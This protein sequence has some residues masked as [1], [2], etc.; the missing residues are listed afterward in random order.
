[1]KFSLYEYTFPYYALDSRPKEK[2]FS[3][4]SDIFD[5]KVHWWLTG[6]MY[7]LDLKKHPPY[8]KNLHMSA[9]IDLKDEKLVNAFMNGVRTTTQLNLTSSAWRFKKSGETG[10][11]LE[12]TTRYKSI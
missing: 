2:L 10:V 8:S 1:M 12:W 9:Y 6:F 4:S 7:N 11:K 5:K 3:I